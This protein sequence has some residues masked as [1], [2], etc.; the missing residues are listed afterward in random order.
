MTSYVTDAQSGCKSIELLL[1]TDLHSTSLLRDIGEFAI[2]L[3]DSVRGGEANGEPSTDSNSSS[4]DEGR[5]SNKTGFDKLEEYFR[6]FTGGRKS[7]KPKRAYAK[8]NHGKIVEALRKEFIGEDKI[9]K[10][11]EIDLVAEK[12]KHALLF[13]VKTCTD[14]HSTYTAIGQL[15]VHV[16]PTRQF[17]GKQVTQIIVVSE[18][19]MEHITDVTADEL[20]FRLVTYSIDKQGMVRFQDLHLL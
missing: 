16:S 17:T 20:N 6:E 9:Y 2:E 11:R 3:R 13:E 14:T 18:H 8:S 12:K 1:I 5:Q 7:S 19:P 4:T 15:S 10:S